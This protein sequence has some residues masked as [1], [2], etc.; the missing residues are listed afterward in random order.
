MALSVGRYEMKQ[1]GTWCAGIFDNWDDAL[2]SR[3]L[4]ISANSED[5]AVD[6]AAAQ[7][8]DA[9]RIEFVCLMS[10]LP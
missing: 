1:K 8:G 5:E 7:M 3:S 2:P 10:E 4:M 9:A 6:R